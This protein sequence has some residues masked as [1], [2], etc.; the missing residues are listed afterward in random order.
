MNAGSRKRFKGLSAV[1]RPAQ[2]DAS[3]HDVLVVIGVDSNLAEVHR[4]ERVQAHAHGAH[5]CPGL[6]LVLGAKDSACYVLD[7]R[8]DDRRI[9]SVDVQ[10]DASAIAGWKPFRQPL[11]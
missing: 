1:T 6:A 11:P 4:A 9:L 3:E 2:A 8:V 5:L 10:S 7:A